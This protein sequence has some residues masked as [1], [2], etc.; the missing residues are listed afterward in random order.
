MHGGWRG[1]RRFYI[2]KI[3]EESE[4][5]KSFYLVPCDEQA[6][7]P[8]QAGQYLAV[9]C[10]IPTENNRQIRQYSLSHASNNRSYRISVK[11]DNLVSGYLHS[12]PEGAE[13]DI[14]PVAGDFVLKQTD[15]PKVLISA[16][17]GITPMMAMLHT[18]AERSCSAQLH[19]LH[20][21]RSPSQLSFSDELAQA[22]SSLPALTTRTWI[23]EGATGATS[24]KSS[25]GRMLLAPLSPALPLEIG[26][27]YLCGPTPF[28]ANIKQQLLTLGVDES[29]ILYE[30]FGP[31]ESL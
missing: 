8:Y 29:R 28:M 5:V 21:C 9:C 15:I 30:V 13:L 22:A 3:V 4:L 17:V 6:V 25:S 23:E 7:M 11:R 16:G 27:F 2:S 24:E 31:H 10:S 20:A 14:M 19:F 12:L 1:T 18:L 26:E